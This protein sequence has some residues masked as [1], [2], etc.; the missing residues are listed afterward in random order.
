MLPPQDF[1]LL[2]Y[3]KINYFTYLNFN[4]REKFKGKFDKMCEPLSKLYTILIFLHFL[5]VF[6]KQFIN[7]IFQV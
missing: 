4:N 2:L 5:G 3:F 7:N 1:S 6:R